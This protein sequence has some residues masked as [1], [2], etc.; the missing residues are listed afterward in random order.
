M[1]FA[2]LLPAALGAVGGGLLVALAVSA[3]A[4]L[5][6]PT[7]PPWAICVVALG[8]MAGGVLAPRLASPPLDQRLAAA[9][10]AYPVLRARFPADYAALRARVESG[11]DTP[12][13]LRAA[14]A[15]LIA[16]RLRAHGAELSDAT[17]DLLIEVDLDEARAVRAADPLACLSLFAREAPA[18]DIA[19][20]V[21]PALTARRN[22]AEAA[23]LEQIATHP[24]RPP[25][26][27]NTESRRLLV[28]GALISLPRA[29]S[30]VV[31]PFIA[32]QVRP[33]EATQARAMCDYNI[34]L[35]SEALRAPP[36]VL[37][38]LMIAP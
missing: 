32:F 11:P 24:A 23:A 1:T 4:R 3:R 20:L 29:T 18:R 38:G 6:G 33:A 12:E 19:A 15:P 27:L 37:R 14:G 34:A 25:A 13:D 31:Q 17:S 36:G 28:E 26:P 30:R 16:D 10:V 21:G 5:R 8:A 22:A 7:P 9:S 2:S 35:Y